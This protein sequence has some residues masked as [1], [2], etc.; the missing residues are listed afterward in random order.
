MP[1]KVAEASR[2]ADPPWILTYSPG[3]SGPGV[4]L[5][6]GHNDYKYLPNESLEMYS[7]YLDTNSHNL[8]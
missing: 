3:A 4:N 6:N 2:R 5:L 7:P 1:F 8:L